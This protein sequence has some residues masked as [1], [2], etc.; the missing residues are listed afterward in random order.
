[1][2]VT[3]FSIE[4]LDRV[5]EVYEREVKG[6]KTDLG[7]HEGG[8]GEDRDAKKGDEEGKEGAK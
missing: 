1:M 4:M 6:K 7:S 8:K 5:I 2:L 3:L